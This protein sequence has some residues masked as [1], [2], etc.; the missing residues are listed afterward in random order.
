[1]GSEFAIRLGIKSDPIEYRYSYPWL[2]RLMAEEGVAHLQLGTFFELYQLP[3]VF[4]SELRRQAA[5]FGVTIDS[6]FTAHR[7]LGGFFREEPGWEELAR[8][9]YERLIEVASW[10][11]ARCAGSNPGAIL[12]DR[13]GG[14]ADG[15]ARYLRHMKE[16]M[17]FAHAR[18]VETLTM[19]PMS[20]LAEPPTLPE[21]IR[22]FAEELQAYH[23]AHP[24]TAGMGYCADTSHGYADRDANVVYTHIELLEA[25]YPHLVELHLKNTDALFSSTFGFSETERAKGIVD[26]SA[27]RDSLHAHAAQI[28]KKDLVAY[29]EIGG[30]KTGRDYSDRRLE[31]ALRDSLRHLRE[32]FEEPAIVKPEI[33]PDVRSSA[34]PV[35]ISASLM[36]ADLCHLEESVRR[37]EAAGVDALHIDIMD[38]RFT[39]N[40]PLGFE[41]FRQLRPLTALPFDA[42][43]MVEDND[44]FVRQAK[45]FGAD[46]VSVHVESCRHLDRTLSLIHSLGMRAGAALNPATALSAVEYVLDKL[47]FVLIMTVN[48]GYAGQALVPGAFRKIAECRALLE[49]H[50][51][52]IPIEV[53]GNVSFEHIPKMV[54]AGAGLLVT[55][56]SSV[57]HRDAPLNENVRKT[58]ECIEE[59]LLLRNA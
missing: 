57:F 49:R 39:P 47:D 40:M 58:R 26:L 20:C 54:G 2:F 46:W 23:T 19:E 53:D 38:A 31:E 56:S 33:A 42:H 13:M 50:G 7:E 34:C 1:M 27:I 3:S 45:A 15:I 36:C 37:L 8:K 16:L 11:G 17:H 29:L 32:V 59:G 24:D 5:D 44:F 30:P 4:F 52:D 9:N 55:G 12:R 28:P 25:T 18:Y 48:P 51:I 21:E 43:L 41:T 6:V 10:V 22:A 14:R 35:R